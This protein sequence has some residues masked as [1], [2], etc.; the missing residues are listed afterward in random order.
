MAKLHELLAAEKTPTGA[1]NTIYEE[2]LKKLKTDHYFSGHTKSLKML[3]DNPENQATEAAARE[4]KEV[5][6]TVI[7]TMD[8]ALKMWLRA[9]DVQFQKNHTNQ[10][11]TGTVMWEGK[12]LL[13]DMPVD[14]LLGLEARLTKIRELFMAIPTL[15]ASVVWEGDPQAGIGRWVTKEPI[16]TAKTEKRVFPI[17][18]HPATDKHPAQI[19]VAS[20]DDP[21]G[22]FTQIKRSG[23]ATAAEK[24][25]CIQNIDTLIVEVKRA[26]MR[27]NETEVI[28]SPVMSA[29]VGILL[30]P[31][32]DGGKLVTG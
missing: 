17:I 27:A 23:A 9:E 2:T 6:T 1:W 14:Q 20:K 19:Q 30:Q 11:A 32:K 15:D 3:I 18:M 24:A 26:R 10:R 29:V 8:Y 28:A 25:A 7:E 13:Q 12:P 5:V 21:V 16:E 4:H 22:L 31:L